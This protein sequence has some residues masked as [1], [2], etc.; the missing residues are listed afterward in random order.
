MKTNRK[1]IFNHKLTLN[2]IENEFCKKTYKTVNFKSQKE[3]SYL[4]MLFSN[5]KR[6]SK[7]TEHVAYLIIQK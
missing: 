6:F 3:K 1:R 2:L 5:F 4:I 7:D